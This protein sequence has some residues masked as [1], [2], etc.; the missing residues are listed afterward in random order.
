MR[1]VLLLAVLTG[2]SFE[3]STVPMPEESFEA[4]AKACPNPRVY[5]RDADRDGVGTTRRARISC[6][7]LG[8]YV[9]EGGDCNDLDPLRYPGAT[10][11][12][13]GVDQDCDRVVDD[14]AVGT[15][16]WFADADEDGY[17]DATVSQ[18]ACTAPAGMVDNALDCKDSDAAVSPK[19]EETCDNQDND[20]DGQSDEDPVDPLT[21]YRDQDGDGYGLEG[22]DFRGCSLP[23]GFATVDGDCNDQNASISPAGTEVCDSLDNNC[24]G[25]ADNDATDAIVWYMDKDGDGSADPAHPMEGCSPPE[26]A[27]YVADDCDDST[28]LVYPEMAEFCD[29]LDNDCDGQTDE[30][31]N[32]AIA[33]Y[34][35]A[36]GD[37]FGNPEVTAYECNLPEGY[38]YNSYDCDDQDVRLPLY[39]D[40][41]GLSNAEGSVMDPLASIQEAVDREAACVVVGP[42]TYSEDLDL[43]E[44][45]GQLIGSTGSP[46]TILQGSGVGPVVHSVD[47][48]LEMNGFTIQ[49][50]GPED[51]TFSADGEGNC[52]GLR[53]GVGGGILAE[54][55]S[56]RLID[57]IIRH[58]NV[59]IPEEPVE[60]GCDMISMSTGGGIYASDSTIWVSNLMLLNNAADEVVSI[61]L[62]SSSLTGS[63]IG[64]MGLGEDHGMVELSLEAGSLDVS[65]MLLNGTASVGLLASEAPVSLRQVTV[66]GYELGMSTEG[67]ASLVNAILMGNQRAL[68]GAWEVSYSDFYQNSIIGME[69]VVGMHGNLSA[70]PLFLQWTN[71]GDPT[72]DSYFLAYNSPV[73]DA[74]QPGVYDVDGSPSDMGAMGGPMGW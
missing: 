1:S 45:Q 68:S 32:D 23:P 13:D 5:Y 7:P 26:D 71:D 38:T 63:R 12:C 35:D 66:G 59:E 21:F 2:C 9:S 20:C 73:A 52:T 16:S 47:G 10:E 55:S 29:G 17:G 58:N 74:G 28:A 51:W 70:D 48:Y 69:G 11:V 61:D 40:Q 36:D 44:Y 43:S 8:G 6:V 25:E 37:G 54:D 41:S 49:G 56:L 50:G 67:S 27:R 42:G 34:E 64:I 46:H 22:P 3:P 62:Y 4:M 72:N 33:A 19:A 65:N 14:N 18:Q 39:V 53:V 15:R 60:S 31:G 30:A 24:D 57:V